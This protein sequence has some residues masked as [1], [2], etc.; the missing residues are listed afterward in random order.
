MACT[1]PVTDAGYSNPVFVIGVFRSGTSLLYSL[2]NQHPQIALMYEC[3]VWNFPK[4]FSRFRLKG[5][6]LE[7]QEFYNQ[8]L[9]RHRL[10]YGGGVRGLEDIK[11]PGDLY[12]VFGE[13][14]GAILWGEKS[15]FY[16][17]RLQ[18]LARQHPG[19]T[20]ILIWRDPVEV[21]RSVLL[22]GRKAR[23]FRRNGVLSRLIVYQEKMIRQATEL[24]QSGARIHH[25]TYADLIDNTAEVCQKICRFLKVDFDPA[26]LDLTHADLSAVYR[27]PQHEY[28]RRGVIERQVCEEIVPPEI[29]QKLERFRTRWSR[30][31]RTWFPPKKPSESTIEPSLIERSYHHTAGFVFCAW[32]EIKRA[33][34][35]FLPL[36]WLQTYR[37]TVFWLSTSHRAQVAPQGG[38]RKELSTHLGTILGSYLLL[39]GLVMIHSWCDPRFTL[40]PFYVIPCAILTAFVNWRWGMVAALISSTVGPALMSRADPDFADLVL[41]L[42]NS[43]MRF[44]LLQFVV[45]LL[46]RLLAEIKSKRESA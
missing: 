25:V 38:F 6:W 23:F 34:F 39:G 12:R 1:S 26:M 22:A 35:E 33:L 15:P 4:A 28:L 9:S 21:Y 24:E 16:C 45:F 41:I 36:S 17:F 30:V 42:W 3:D 43:S 11:S 27:A 40:L 18:E 20:F 37:Q 13:G 8:G 46:D 10:I 5:S 2:L 14:K 32:D 44:L 19:C 31:N 29:A 7:R